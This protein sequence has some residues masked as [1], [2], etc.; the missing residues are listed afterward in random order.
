MK[1]NTLLIKVAQYILG[2][3]RVGHLAEVPADFGDWVTSSDASHLS[4]NR[5][6]LGDDNRLTL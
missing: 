6:F 4:I 3:P 5:P 2:I 1:S